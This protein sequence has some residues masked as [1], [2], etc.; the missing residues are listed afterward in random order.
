MTT[1]QANEM[2][3]LLKSLIFAVQQ[4]N[5]TLNSIKTEIENR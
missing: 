4:T 5:S 1:Q 2:I 3:E